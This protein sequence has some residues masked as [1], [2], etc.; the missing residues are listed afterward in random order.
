MKALFS[1]SVRFNISNLTLSQPVPF[2]SY[3][4]TSRSAPHWDRVGQE[5]LAYSAKTTFL[6][7]L[8]ASVLV[9]IRDRI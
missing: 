2:F 6:S 3:S 4:R 7:C 9:L 8:H 1:K 5:V